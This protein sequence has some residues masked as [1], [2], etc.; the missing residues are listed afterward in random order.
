MR[1]SLLY[2]DWGRVLHYG[3]RTLAS[4]KGDKREIL[5]N[6]LIKLAY[7]SQVSN[8]DRSVLLSSGFDLAKERGASTPMA[9]IETLVVNTAK[10][11]KA[12][13]VVNAL[14]DARAYT[15]HKE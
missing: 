1:I 11:R 12:S 5:I 7:V 8:G 6:T 15:H 13:I 3:G 14:A 2:W 10:P 4:I 9:T